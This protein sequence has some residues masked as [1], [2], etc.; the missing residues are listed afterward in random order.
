MSPNIRGRLLYNSYTQ[1]CSRFGRRNRALPRSAQALLQSIYAKDP[2]SQV[3]MNYLEGVMFPYIFPMESFD[4]AVIG[5]LPHSMFIKPLQQHSSRGHIGSIGDHMRIRSNDFS[6]IT[7][8][9][10]DYSAH[11][12]DVLTNEK[13]NHN[14]VSLLLKKGPEFLT[15]KRGDGLDVGSKD[16]GMLFDKV[17]S[18]GPVNELAAFL[19][20]MGKSDYFITV[21]ANQ[22]RTP[23]LASLRKHLVNHCI[24]S[25]L[26]EYDTKCIM[27]GF[28]P[29]MLQTF[30]R[31]V[32][33]MWEWIAHGGDE[34][35][36]PVK[37]YW[38]R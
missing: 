6:L 3:S 1:I 24:K 13:L 10:V 28:M 11:S 32:R 19:K 8:S 38:Y 23:G 26:N 25:E 30:Y 2:K 5:A 16:T 12:Y 21:T 27:L 33:Y 35:C 22:E 34:P 15:K 14:M 4:G 20:T 36:G 37:A 29:L 9:E 7:A 17:E 18:H 31:T